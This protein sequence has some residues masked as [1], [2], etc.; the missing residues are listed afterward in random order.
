M[1]ASI[2]DFKM[3]RIDGSE[4]AL[5]AYKGKVALVV[6]V[7]S[8]C[9][10][11]PQ[12]QG[13]EKV[14]ETYRDKGFTVLGF[15][16]NEFKGQEPGSNAEIAEFCTTNFGV[17]FPMFEK[18]VVKGDGQ[19]PFYKHL[20][21]A[22]KDAYVRPDSKFADLLLSKGLLTGAPHDIKWNFEKFVVGKDGKVAARFA[23]DTP[24]DDPAI[25]KA[26][27]AELAKA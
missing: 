27:E 23:P 17:K 24:P 14:Y 5:S 6:N 19:H 26:I 7:A 11:T 1:A 9:G 10:L 15:P 13:L 21:E 25:V 22:K 12:Y 18:I 4:E 8:K 3:R 16:A 2:H 20:T